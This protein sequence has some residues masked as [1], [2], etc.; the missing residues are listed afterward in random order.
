MLFAGGKEEG[1]QR[2]RIWKLFVQMLLRMRRLVGIS[3]GKG[4][5]D[6]LLSEE[7]LDQ[8]RDQITAPSNKEFC[9]SAVCHFVL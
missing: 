4:G 8:L 2:R 1:I 9:L 5:F 3:S 6:Q 7:L